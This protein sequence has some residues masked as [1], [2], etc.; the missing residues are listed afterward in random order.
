MKR[1]TR[2]EKAITLIALII[3]IVVLLI[4]A[5]VAI[6]AVTGDGIIQHATNAKVQY[7]NAQAKEQEMI[8]AYE[9]YLKNEL[10]ENKNT[11]L[12]ITSS[13]TGVVFPVLTDS[14]GP[15]TSTYAISSMPTNRTNVTKINATN[16]TDTNEIDR[17]KTL[18]ASG[19][20]II[21]NGYVYGYNV[22]RIC[23]GDKLR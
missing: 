4:L 1:K 13:T 8:S 16:R 21:Y 6:N 11:E 10:G 18:P 17:I 9:E 14:E 7:E 19:D 15:S 23:N 3:T 5:V 2:E 20:V 22:H 12:K